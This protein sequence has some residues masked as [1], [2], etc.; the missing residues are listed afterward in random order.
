MSA[1]APA[2]PAPPLFGVLRRAYA[3]KS[4]LL[5]SLQLKPEEPARRERQQIGQRP[6]RGEA[7]PSE[8]LLRDHTGVLREVEL[9][10]LGGAGEIV[11][12][13]HDVLFPA[14]DVG[15]DPRVIRAQRLVR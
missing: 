15:K 4:W 6:D 12:A 14:A 1:P 8:H 10:G 3:R 9:D 5:S 7:R 13:Q 2:K 11:H